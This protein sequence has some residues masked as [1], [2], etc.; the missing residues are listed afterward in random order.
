M[1]QETFSPDNV[2][3]GDFPLVTDQV[4]LLSG[5]NLS[6]GSVLGKVTASGKYKLC[7]VLASDGS[8]APK[9]VLVNDTDA[10]GGDAANTPVYLTG[11]FNQNAIGLGGTTSAAAVK[12]ALRDLSI[13]LKDSVQD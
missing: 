6:R 9:V 3:A 8:E 5:E 11:E 10:S 7:D 13:F 12:D 4:T 1:A 2:I